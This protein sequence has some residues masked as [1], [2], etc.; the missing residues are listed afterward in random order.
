[1]TNLSPLK[2]GI[3][4]L[5]CILA[6]F[7]LGGALLLYDT[8]EP[9]PLQGGRTVDVSRCGFSLRI[10][11][12]YSLQ[13]ITSQVRAQ[14][15]EAVYAFSAG[16]GADLLLAYVFDNLRADEISDTPEQH[17]VSYYMNAGCD[18]VRPRD[19]SGRRF[20]CYRYRV[21]TGSSE[22][23]WYV[24]ETWSPR[25]HLIFETPMR[26]A[27]VLPILQTLEFSGF[28]PGSSTSV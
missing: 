25:W 10:P 21:E 2:L 28:A 23:R 15:E 12:G 11:E 1:M 16:D 24:Y 13:E 20:I 8:L 6:G 14:D 22:E 27:D 18:Q 9:S 3:T 7:A 17:L 19:L 4:L 5:L 26:E